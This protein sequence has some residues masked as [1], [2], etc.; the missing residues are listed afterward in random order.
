MNVKEYSKENLRFIEVSND[1]KLRVI[2]SDLGASIYQIYFDDVLMTR[3]ALEIKDFKN[4]GCYYGKTIGRTTNRLK[5][6]RFEIN[7]EIYSLEPNEGN[8]VLHGGVNGLSTKRFASS[9]STY[10]DHIEVIYVYHSGH[11]EAGYPG[12]VDIKVTYFIYSDSD[13]LEV[14]YEAISDMDTLFSLTN[15]SYFTLGEKDLSTLDLFIRSHK[16]IKPNPEDLIPVSVDEVN[17]VFDFT[18]F[19]NI[20]KDIEDQ[21]LKGTRLNGYD[22]YFYFDDV[23]SGFINVSL[24]GQKYRLD[25]STNFPGTQ[26]YT[27]NYLAPFKLEGEVN[28]IRDSVAIEPSDPFDKYPVLLKN[29]RYSRRIIYS[30]KE[31]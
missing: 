28:Y 30:F 7:G 27:S 17:E 2:F 10:N 6:Y 26:I 22:H 11:L 21:S 31:L 12:N 13:K 5:G 19:K 23:S 20:N 14:S 18:K 24:L 4:I 9:I 16:Y 3:N 29:T 1:S 15:H 25:I 8:N